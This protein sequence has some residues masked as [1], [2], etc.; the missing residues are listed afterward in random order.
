[1][2]QIEKAELPILESQQIHNFINALDTASMSYFGGNNLSSSLV[3]ER[4]KSTLVK[5]HLSPDYPSIYPNLE[6]PIK[7]Q[8]LSIPKSTSPFFNVMTMALVDV[9]YVVQQA[10]YVW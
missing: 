2:Y 3:G 9:Q 8:R 5:V 10:T 6:L 4:N 1:M 7:T